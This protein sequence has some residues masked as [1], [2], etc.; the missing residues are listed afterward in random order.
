LPVTNGAIATAIALAGPG[1]YSLDPALGL[2]V[3]RWL[4]ALAFPSGAVVVAAGFSAEP[5]DEGGD[6]E[7]DSN[8]A[9][10]E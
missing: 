10:N 5:E 2:R 1:R 7:S 6:G 3:R 8:A 4:V 9:D